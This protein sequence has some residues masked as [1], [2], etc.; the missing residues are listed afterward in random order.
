[1]QLLKNNEFMK[2]LGKWMKLENII[3][4]EVTLLKRTHMICTDWLVAISPED[5]NSQDTN[6]KPNETQEGMPKYGYFDPS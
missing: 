3:P 5:H 2:F 1:M 6:Y 4:S